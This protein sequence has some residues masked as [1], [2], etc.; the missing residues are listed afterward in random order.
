M[1]ESYIIGMFQN[2]LI[3]NIFCNCVSGYG[4]ALPMGLGNARRKFINI[5][6]CPGIFQDIMQNTGN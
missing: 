1:P 6:Y 2:H 5:L 4:S 3:Q